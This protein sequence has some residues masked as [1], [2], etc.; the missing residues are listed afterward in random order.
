[1]S[2]TFNSR[3]IDCFFFFIFCFCLLILFICHT[4]VLLWLCRLRN[5]KT[6]NGTNITVSGIPVAIIILCIILFFK[7]Y[8]MMI[9]CT[10]WNLFTRT[11][12][13]YT[14]S[15]TTFFRISITITVGINFNCSILMGI[16]GKM[17]HR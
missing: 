15:C 4:S 12:F 8:I 1:M 2:C 16:T 7:M 5:C 10:I 14:T 13:A 6:T 3:I 17:F 11:I 9:M